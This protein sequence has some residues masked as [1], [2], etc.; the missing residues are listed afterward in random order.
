MS[1]IQA[2]G[3]SHARENIWLAMSPADYKI[4]LEEQEIFAFTKHHRI[5]HP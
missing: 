3:D 2:I 1:A 5:H 4:S